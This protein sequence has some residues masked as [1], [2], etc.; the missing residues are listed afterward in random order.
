MLSLVLARHQLLPEL[1]GKRNEHMK[2]EE[3]TDMA[4][5]YAKNEHK[6]EE[7]PAKPTAQVDL[8]DEQLEQVTGGSIIMDS[9]TNPAPWP[10]GP[11]AIGPAI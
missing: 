10:P 2:N 3:K 6:P 8:T 5:E 9:V 7:Q 1:E 4:N 11:S